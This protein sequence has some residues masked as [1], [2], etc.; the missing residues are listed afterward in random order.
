MSLAP[1]GGAKGYLKGADSPKENSTAAFDYAT[2]GRIQLG[3]FHKKR[4]QFL[5][6]ISLPKSSL[7]VGRRYPGSIFHRSAR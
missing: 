1:D 2:D 7:L 3:A 6:F 4:Q 5:V